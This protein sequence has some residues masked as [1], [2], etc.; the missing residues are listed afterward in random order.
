MSDV[1]ADQHL[2]ERGVTDLNNQNP[3]YRVTIYSER[4]GIVHAWMPDEFKMQL[5]QTWDFIIGGGVTGIVNAVAQ[6]MGSSVFTQYQTAKVWCGSHPISF[7]L[8]LTFTARKNSQ[9]EVIDPIKQLMKMS[10]PYQLSGWTVRPPGPSAVAKFGRSAL[11]SVT[12]G[13]SADNFF[14]ALGGSTGDK[15]VLYIGSYI[16]IPDIYIEGVSVTFSSTI[17]SDG[18]PMRGEC[19]LL[20]N[21]MYAPTVQNVDSWISPGVS[22]TDRRPS[23]STEGLGVANTFSPTL[24]RS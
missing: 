7:S 21:T 18:N 4:Y 19:F 2:E 1:G 15:L 5:N 13:D 24:P 11:R 6:V 12:P 3:Y 16:R 14:D 8:P 17:D 23:N 20:C 22:N 9:K 10:V